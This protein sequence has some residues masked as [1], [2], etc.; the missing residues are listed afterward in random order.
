MEEYE[1]REKGRTKRLPTEKANKAI[2]RAWIVG[3]IWAGLTLIAA[4]ISMSKGGSL[5]RLVDVFLIFGLTFG[6]YRKSRIC[7]VIIFVYC[8]V[9]IILSSINA[10]RP[11]VSAGMVF[12]LYFFFQGIRG[13]FAYHK[14]TETEVGKEVSEEE[15]SE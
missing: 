3:L 2:K 5:W 14:I 11:A 1:Q 7:A 6:I 9:S 15:P 8:V 10:G 12:L 13:T 4:L